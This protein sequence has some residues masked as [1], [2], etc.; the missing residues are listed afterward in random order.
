M[1]ERT[2]PKSIEIRTEL[3]DTQVC[4]EADPVHLEQAVVNIAVNARDAMN[5]AGTLWIRGDL[6]AG[7]A[8]LRVTDTGI[9]MDEATRLR[10][11]EPFFTTKPL[12]KGTGLGLSTVWGI[13]QAHDGTI[14]VE[15]RPGMGSTFSISLPVSSANPTLRMSY[16]RLPTADERKAL[17]G[18]VM[19]VDDEEAVR[20]TSK[21]LLERMGLDVITAEHGEDALAKLT[22]AIELVV[23]DMGMPVMGG[24]ECFRRIRERSNVPVLIATGYAADEDAQAIVAQ[25]ASL[26][27]KPFTSTQLKHEV[28]RLLA[29][30]SRDADADQESLDDRGRAHLVE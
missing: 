29:R 27:E 12:G 19:V 10:L 26:L 25:G 11:F 7:R 21:R 15:S 1:L 5:G 30:A 28:A 9:G 3:P 16:S 13:V 14:T 23:L 8:R 24:P 22:P 18:T 20:N 17:R 6:H 4:V 2:L